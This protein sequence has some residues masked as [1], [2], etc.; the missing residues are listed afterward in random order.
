MEEARRRGIL[1]TYL[2]GFGREQTVS[3]A[4]IRKLLFAL[5]PERDPS[6][7]PE[8]IVIREQETLDLPEPA[9]LTLENGEKRIIERIANIPPGYHFLEGRWDGRDLAA[10]L[11]VCP[12]QMYK[13]P[14]GQRSAGIAIS[15]YGLRSRRNWGTGDLRDLCEFVD[16]AAEAGFSLV[17]LNPLH[18]IPNRQ[19]FNTSPYLPQCSYYRNFLYLDVEALD[20]F[21][22][23]EIQA[24]FHSA[25][26]QQ[27][28]AAL[29]ESE[30]IEYERVAALK[31]T[32]L[33]MCFESF[34]PADH[35]AY[36]Q[37]I[38][39][40]G[41]FLH[42]FAVY[43]ALDAHFRS[44]IA[45]LWLWTDW[46]E[47]YHDPGSP[48]CQS[49]ARDHAREL[50][51]YCWLQ[52]HLDR[53]LAEVQA[54]AKSRGMAVG[55]YHD[56]ALATDRTGCDLWANPHHFVSGCRVGAPPDNF[57]PDGQD[58]S[59]PP[60]N[61]ETHLKDGYHLFAASIRNNAS[62][63]GALRID[64]VMRLFRLFWIPDGFEAKDGTYVLERWRDLFGI[65]ALESHRLRVRI[66]GE[67]LGT[68]T[69]E[70]RDAL[71]EQGVLGYRILFFERN[72]NFHPP[73]AYPE[74]AVA[75]TATHDLATLAGFWTGNDIEARRNAGLLPDQADYDRQIGQRKHDKQLLLDRLHE[76]HLLPEEYPHDATEIPE[77][78][79][80]LRDAC[81]EF[82]AST[83]CEFLVL[84]QEDLT[85]ELYQQNLPGSTSEYPN[86]RR[87]MKLTVE[88]LDTDQEMRGLCGR[89]RDLLTRTGRIAG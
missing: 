10:H 2:D 57:S 76:L 54:R 33:R 25:E 64:H 46:P 49:F 63:G 32:F 71:L 1:L 89:L 5:G 7:P 37:F 52:W 59:F 9:T 88:E 74:A 81:L 23:P 72:E 78:A 38:D 48:A 42:E 12:P 65:L 67:D 11:I 14:S 29:R 6:A 8:T 83:P 45:G 27:E 61:G 39:R 53:Q 40:E 47:D 68:I 82:L 62:H 80:V 17:A 87:K 3:G 86:W 73:D 60:P 70:M 84:N 26:V 13:P 31:L 4:V 69:Q 24:A 51:F 56:L 35:P 28:I 50:V 55:L 36:R 85:G 43:C 41:D 34:R 20:E 66:I 58:W 30:F 44:T 79:S 21:R 22:Q 16:W 15:L 77:L 19:P 75:S 18:A